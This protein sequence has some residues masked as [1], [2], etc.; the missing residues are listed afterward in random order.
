MYCGHGDTVCISITI[1]ISPPTYPQS[2]GVEGRA[3]VSRDCVLVHTHRD[4]LQDM[5]SQRPVNILVGVARGGA[6]MLGIVV[7]K[8]INYQN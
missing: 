5:F 7:A 3:R 6:R 4:K 8:Y 2:A 1:I